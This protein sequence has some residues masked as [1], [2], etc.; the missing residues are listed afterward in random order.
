[1]AS[2][3]E[4]DQ[5]PAFAIDPEEAAAN[6]SAGNVIVA[7]TVPVAAASGPGADPLLISRMPES[8]LIPAPPFPKPLRIWFL[9]AVESAVAIGS[10]S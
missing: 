2:A 7:S 9:S 10:D 5:V 4:S 8:K 3:L 6:A 1:V